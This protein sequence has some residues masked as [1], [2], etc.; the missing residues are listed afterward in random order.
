[1]ATQLDLFGTERQAIPIASHVPAINGD[2]VPETATQP[3]SDSAA[4][5]SQSEVAAHP[6]SVIAASERT[7]ASALA[8]PG[9]ELQDF[10]ERLEGARKFLAP[11]LR[12]ELG[13]DQIAALP[14]SK[15]W[16]A[17]AHEAIEN[18]AAAALAF[19]ARQ[20]IPAKPR[21]A[22]KVRHWV[23]KVKTYRS[24]VNDIGGR[25]AEGQTVPELEQVAGHMGFNTLAPFFARV[26][27]LS[28]LPRAAWGR[29]E[30]AGEY[31]D[32][33]RQK[34]A[35]E[36][37]A[38]DLVT[39]PYDAAKPYLGHGLYR[40]STGDELTYQERDVAMFVAAPFSSVTIDGKTHTFDGVGQL[41]PDEV[42]RVREL[43]GA[44]LP[45]KGG[46][47]ASDFEIR[48]R[49]RGGAVFVN[50]K[51]DPEH[52]ALREF[53]GEDAL[54]QA[55][56]WITNHPDE[57]AAAWEAV[58][59][60]DNVGKADVRRDTN[61]DRSGRD[62]R[63]G[64][65]VTPEMFTEAFG[66]RGTQFGNWVGQ[67][68]GAKDR[69]GLLNAAYESLHDL[70]DILS[71]PT[72]AIS[73]NG[74]LGLSLGARGAGNASAHFE[75][76]NL[77]I[78]LTKTR[79]AGTLAH[80]W[81]HALDNYFARMRGGEVP[82]TGNQEAYRQ[83]NYITYKPEAAW[84]RIGSLRTPPLTGAQ[85]RAR[86]RAQLSYDE[87]KTLA[88]N[89]QSAGYEIDPQHKEGVRP[90]VEKAFASLVAALNESP[91]AQRASTLDKAAD[92]Y[93]G[94]I[95]E[96]GARSFENYVVSKLAQRG[97]TNDFL[98]N[99]R[100]WE[101]W[102]RLGKNADR[103]PY[104]RPEEEAPIIGAFD[105][106][107]ETV[108]TRE[109][110]GRVA[111]YSMSGDSVPLPVSRQVSQ[112]VAAD[113]I[114]KRIGG[115]AHQPPIR[116]E[117]RAEGIVPGARDDDGVSGA[118]YNGTIYLFRD[119]LSSRTDVQRTL[120]HELFHYGLKRFLTRDEYET[121]MLLLYGR[122]AWIA[123]RADEWSQTQ[124][125]D[126][127][128]EHG[129]KTYARA[130][131]VEE[132]LARLAEPNAGH[133]LQTSVTQR[134]LRNVSSW[135]ANL[136]DK[137]GF[138][139]AAAQIR[140]WKNQEARS[141]IQSVF[142]R[143]EID[144]APAQEAWGFTADTAFR[145]VS[146][147]TVV[148][149]E[150]P[151]F[152]AWFGKSKVVDVDGAPQVMYHG[153]SRDFGTFDREMSKQW[154]RAFIDNIGS[155]FSS[156]PAR[157]EQ[158]AGGEGHQV[159]PVYLTI[160]KPKVYKTFAA[161]LTDMHKAAGR[162]PKD[163]KPPGLGS[164]EELRALLQATGFD[165]VRLERTDVQSLHD[166]IAELNQQ[167]RKENDPSY[168]QDIKDDIAAVSK[169][170][171]KFG[172][173]TEFDGHDVWIAFEPQQIKS[174]IGNN[175]KFDGMNTDIRFS[176]ASRNIAFAVEPSRVSSE[177]MPIREIHKVI[178]RMRGHWENMPRV[179]VVQDTAALPFES[180]SN[181][182]GAYHDGQVYVVA[183]NIADLKQLHKVMAHECV[184]HH[185]LE[186]ML[187]A[188]GFSKLHHGVQALKTGGDP[189][190]CAIA[191]NV[192]SRYGELV[193]EIETKEIVARA[194]ELCL[195]EHGQVRVEYGF[196]KGVFAGVT[197]WLRDHGI[198]VPFT[199]VELQGILHNAGEWTRGRADQKTPRGVDSQV[200]RTGNHVG[201]ILSIADDIATQ[202]VGRAGETILHSL[203]SLSRAVN[204][205]ELAEISYRDGM[206]VVNNHQ[207]E[208]SRNIAR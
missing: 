47:T 6:N 137:L 42:E 7:P 164:T 112:A 34:S 55:R 195:D 131:G 152:K 61:R 198:S 200:Q 202:R 181:A 8:V 103:Y 67:G 27:L 114:E 53:V 148:R 37:R 128:T 151:E 86:L 188:Y 107:F 193:A 116:I 68:A 95:I 153:T 185:G 142:H 206:G 118:V 25:L 196:M 149:T 117:D 145:S 159:M 136:A 24:L 98:A 108:Q 182:D 205:G 163:Q 192:R 140:G 119:Q 105:D 175:G 113:E 14:L 59:E 66:F 115:F 158:Y 101:E 20:E 130:R 176:V 191:D 208:A 92:G 96:R 138:K 111:L 49:R 29:I 5:D 184:M 178:D 9:V 18:D 91:M 89:A 30:K 90:E 204:V 135:I 141:F 81:F 85:L 73:L 122:D 120:F 123:E 4:T 64:Q 102:G 139:E 106:L 180:P 35:E 167:L 143:L 41:G 197:G 70:A 154:R 22:H 124:E 203:S 31:P 38:D 79:G 166:E 19:G 183:S 94:R 32:A 174:A 110:D 155:W 199:N 46:L 26:R 169:A 109:I 17:D 126:W 186:E 84:K 15:V 99:V 207:H 75:P 78:N 104:L 187:G 54:K 147:G 201:K 88:A 1:M 63:N 77:V 161:L 129:G 162:S 172:G 156:E 72:Q 80:E 11:S 52:R 58:K 40:I 3:A 173:S 150:T 133:Y 165:G 21:V 50:R 160:A 71:I 23:G 93:W 10:G 97:Q 13:D 16:P 83:S 171:A 65:D 177:S 33:Q 43:V 87:L 28:Q 44:Q 179:H 74:T 56:E 121:Q 146:H 170:I 76:S 12:E 36:L 194:G 62:W 189:T 127:A 57:A 100:D 48:A 45:R 69:Q 132:A 39:R 134:V 157:A 125:G 144:A 51:A 2:T 60:R 82:F 190:V 168:R